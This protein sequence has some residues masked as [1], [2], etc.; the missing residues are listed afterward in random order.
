MNLLYESPA[1]R[2]AE[3]M[4]T[5]HSERKLTAGVGEFEGAFDGFLRRAVQF[6]LG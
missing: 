1:A 6:A 2:A 3:L 4:R 5:I